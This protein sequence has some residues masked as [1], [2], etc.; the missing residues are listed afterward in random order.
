MKVLVAGDDSQV[1]YRVKSI[2][3]TKETYN[4][5]NINGVNTIFTPRL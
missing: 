4:N 5:F 2:G 1:G 3:E